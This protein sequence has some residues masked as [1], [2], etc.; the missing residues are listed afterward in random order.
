MDLP[1]KFPSDS[2]VILE[3][4]AKFQALS[5]QERVQVIR[6]MVDVGAKLQRMSPKADSM[7]QY[8]LDQEVLAQQRV[9]EFITRHGL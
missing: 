2:E 9:L 3:E 5:S 1:I 7:R 8:T 4:A 6:G